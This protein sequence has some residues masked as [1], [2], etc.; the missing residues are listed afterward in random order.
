MTITGVDVHD[1]TPTQWKVENSW[2]DKYGHNGYYT[3]S[4]EWFDKNG[5]IVVVRKKLLSE[6]LQADLKKKPV[7]I[8]VWDPLNSP[9]HRN[10]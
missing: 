7:L 8:P 4:D 5:Y 1:G 6:A 3:M 2:G 9:M 10:A